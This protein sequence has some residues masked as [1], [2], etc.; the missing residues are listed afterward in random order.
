MR[1]RNIHPEQVEQALT[2]LQSEPAI[3]VREQYCADPHLTDADLRVAAIVEGE[4]D[5]IASA[6]ERIEA[7]WQRWLSDYLSNHTCV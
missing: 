5:P 3:L 1:R 2:E 6:A 7:L 4:P